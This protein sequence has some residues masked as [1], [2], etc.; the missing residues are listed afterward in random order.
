MS[1]NTDSRQSRTAAIVPVLF[2][3]IALALTTSAANAQA[4]SDN[5]ND[6]NTAPW[7]TAVDGIDS[8]AVREVNG[9]VEFS[10]T[11]SASPAEPHYIGLRARGWH[12]LTDANVQARIGFRFVKQ[13][14]AGASLRNGV[15]VLVS[16]AGSTPAPNNLTPGILVGIGQYLPFSPSN[17]VWRDVSIESV[18]SAGFTSE[19]YSFLAPGNTFFDGTEPVFNLGDQGTLYV[20]YQ[21]SNDRM[22]FSLTGYGDPYALVVYNA[23]DGLHEPVTISIG[24]VTMSPRFQAGANSW[25]DNLVVDQGAVVRAPRS[26]AATDGTSAGNVKLTWTPGTSVVRYEVFRSESGGARQLLGSVQGNAS[27]EFLDTTA[28]PGVQYSYQVEGVARDGSRVEG[29]N[30]DS[31]W[32]NIPAPAGL[33]ASDGAT[34]ESVAVIWQPVAG[35]TGYEV[36]RKLGSAASVLL[37]TGL[38]DALWIDSTA[39]PLKNYTYSVKALHPLGASAT[40]SNTGWRNRTGPASVSATD[41]VFANKVRVQWSSVAGSQGYRVL[42]VPSPLA[43]AEPEVI[44]TLPATALAFN[45]LT[46]P[47]GTPVSYTVISKHA[48]GW[49]V[50]GASDQGFR[51]TLLRSAIVPPLD[52]DGNGVV[53]AEE[54]ANWLDMLRQQARDPEAEPSSHEETAEDE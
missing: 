18:D 5:F 22:Y 7:W 43:G 21:A 14:R 44:A 50:P 20:R 27:D 32:R 3:V 13:S 51:G 36:R 6:N 23:T 34:V 28:E 17:Q 2:P 1:C 49:S 15:G 29:L 24:G 47:S 38:A 11:A 31:G 39:Q 30:S 26:V 40:A 54:F 41:G 35:A 45:D 37:A 33:V 52:A 8:G 25:L 19:L 46:I 10:T 16:S 4:F 9:R 12:I 42:R 53:E 48:L